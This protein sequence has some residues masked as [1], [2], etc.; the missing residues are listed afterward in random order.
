MVIF[1]VN[2][3]ILNQFGP[4]K[5]LIISTVQL[6]KKIINAF[7]LQSSGYDAVRSPPFCRNILPCQTTWKA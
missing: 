4:I 7:I 1:N 6:Y 5:D 2:F 3:N